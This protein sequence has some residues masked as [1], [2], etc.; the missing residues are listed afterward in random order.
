MSIGRLFTSKRLHIMADVLQKML[1][2]M[3]AT[4]T[5]AQPVGPDAPAS[6]PASTLSS[7]CDMLRQLQDFIL[8]RADLRFNLLTEQA[9][10][11][12]KDGAT[13][14]QVVD[15]RMLNSLTLDARLAGIPC[16]DRDVSRLLASNRLPDFHPMTSYMA[17]LPQWDG[18]D[19]V[20]PL[21]LRISDNPLW[22]NGFHRWMRALAAQWMGHDT[23]CANALAPILVSQRQGLRKST[24]C[25]MLM[26]DALAAYYTDRFDIGAQT[27]CEQRLA[28][29]GLINM[30]E[31]DRYRPS[32]MAS[33]KNLMQMKASQFRKLRTSRYLHLPRM[34]SFIGTSNSFELLSDP[35]GSRRF[36]CV[37]VQGI[38]D[39]TPLEHKQLYAQLRQEV[40]AGEPTFL[41]REEE[42]DLEQSNHRFYRSLPV[43]EVL[44][45]HF[46][47]PLPT[48]DPLSFSSA[49]LLEFLRRHHPAVMRDVTV[50]T[51]S[52]QLLT[53]G[54][55]RRHTK[56]G[57]VFLLVRK[58]EASPL[59]VAG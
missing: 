56:A 50:R 26:P 32:Q 18:V 23:C 51:L 48:D 47:L 55:Q 42:S 10:Y 58:E 28:T 33:L 14:F 35:T 5:T 16:W 46:R 13:E 25:R 40:L 52:D 24:F 27:N 54:V 6:V 7:D 31:F 49:Q 59:K 15:Q 2:G 57:N 44:E 34:A 19:R 37:E 45:Q 22:V 21:A 3:T 11:R 41:T 1:S 38:I 4:D 8:S 20:T 39:C 53:Y 17:S 12:W 30:D 36:L 9:E 43:I 29:T